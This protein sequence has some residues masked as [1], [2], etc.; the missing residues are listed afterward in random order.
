MVAGVVLAKDLGPWRYAKDAA[1]IGQGED[2]GAQRWVDRR[3]ALVEPVQR[4]KRG[5]IEHCQAI[6]GGGEV[7][8]GHLDCGLYKG[9][10]CRPGAKSFRD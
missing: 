6:Q 3:F 2:L 8:K 4:I 5:S 7:L 10:G 1:I 9:F